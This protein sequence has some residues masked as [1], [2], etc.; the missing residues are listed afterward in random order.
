MKNR[1]HV[2]IVRKSSHGRTLWICIVKSTLVKN[3][4]YV[5][6][7]R[8]SSHSR[9]LYISILK[10][11]L[12][13]HQSLM[14]N[15][16]PILIVMRSSKNETTWIGFQRFTL[17]KNHSHVLIVTSRSN[18]DGTWTGIVKFTRRRKTWTLL[19]CSNC[20][21]VAYA[22]NHIQRRKK[23]YIAS[24]V[25]DLTDHQLLKKSL[26]WNVFETVLYVTYVP[27]RIFVSALLRT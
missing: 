8:N 24:T 27:N 16:S 23:Q 17:V 14:R 4:S 10:F 18:E 13:L 3:H 11:T 6:I 7:V 22:V 12:F 26:I 19:I 9:T 2:L 21:G 5:L 20:M 15:R 1:S 25:I